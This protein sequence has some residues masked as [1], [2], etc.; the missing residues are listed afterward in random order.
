MD[1]FFGFNRNFAFLSA[2]LFHGSGLFVCAILAAIAASFVTVPGEIVKQRIMIN[3]SSSAKDLVKNIFE[4]EG[5]LG[6]YAGYGACCLRDV[7]FTVFQLAFYDIIKQLLTKLKRVE[8]LNETDEIICAAITG[9]LT[10]FL[11]APMDLL[12]TKLMVDGHLY[13]GLT[14]CIQKTIENGNGIGALMNGA[15]ARVAWLTPFCAIYLP[16]YDLMK[17]K[18]TAIG[19]AKLQH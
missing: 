7:P 18:I 14:D 13:S 1:Q 3:S 4:T 9:G 12:K 5:V 6:F 11:T 15:G 16:V 17:K 8:K 10:G 19:N 2:I